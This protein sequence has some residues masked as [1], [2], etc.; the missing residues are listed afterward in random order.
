MIVFD[1]W[2][3][4]ILVAYC[5]TSQ[6]RKEDLT[7]WMHALDENIHNTHP[8]WHPNVFIV[9]C[10]QK[11]STTSSKI[12]IPS[13]FLSNKLLTIYYACHLPQWM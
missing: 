5:I 8:S 12:L 4:G 10:A 6:C 9:D 7:P 13:P 3:N 2:H 11:E 1:Q